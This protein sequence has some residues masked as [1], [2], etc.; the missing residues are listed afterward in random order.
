MFGPSQR[1]MEN[2]KQTQWL[3][4]HT[5]T[6]ILVNVYKIKRGLYIFCFFSEDVLLSEIHVEHKK[7]MT[8]SDWMAFQC[9]KSN[10]QS[11]FT[12]SFELK[13]F[14]SIQKPCCIVQHIHIVFFSFFENI[15][16][17]QMYTLRFSVCLLFY[18]CFVQL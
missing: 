5:N 8:D 18:S 12:F 9:I 14:S 6:S 4:I 1:K 3:F 13:A 10:V 17:L 7:F 11:L 2:S 15:Q 16:Q